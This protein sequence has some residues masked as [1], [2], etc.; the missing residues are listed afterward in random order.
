VFF[1]IPDEQSPET[2][3]IHSIQ[4]EVVIRILAYHKWG[5]LHNNYIYEYKERQINTNVSTFVYCAQMS[6]C[7]FRPSRIYHQDYLQEFIIL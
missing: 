2:P 3:V 6:R 7:M 4:G 1:T 5:R